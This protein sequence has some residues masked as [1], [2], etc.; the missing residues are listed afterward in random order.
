MV[1]FDAF[2]INMAPE[3][4][5]TDIDTIWGVATAK[6]R[7]LNK[8][9]LATDRDAGQML[10]PSRLS[11]A[12]EFQNPAEIERHGYEIETHRY[13]TYRLEYSGLKPFFEELG[14]AEAH[15]R[16]ESFYA[17]DRRGGGMLTCTYSFQGDCMGSDFKLAAS[18]KAGLI[19]AME[20][21]CAL[22][23]EA[24]D[25]ER[26]PTLIHWSDFAFLHWRRCVA[27]E[28]SLK[29][30]K[31]ILRYCIT[32]DTTREVIWRIFRQ[33]RKKT[34]EFTH[35]WPGVVVDA[36]TE[37]GQALIGT[38]NGKGV[39]W[40]LAQHKRALGRKVID[41]ITLFCP[42]GE[43]YPAMLLHVKDLQDSNQTDAS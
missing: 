6:G 34:R 39:A 2:I 24:N 10:S 17:K 12:S 42:R 26:L 18:A 27:D 15:E 16:D 38:P 36:N 35:I 1:Y 5:T 33:E 21:Y 13:F 37:E 14:I 19:V 41:N 3:D 7:Y 20:S 25:K 40:L 31:Y 11:A 4:N 9:M 30:L 43:Q 23:F 29:T 8:L 28:D 22:P 32:N